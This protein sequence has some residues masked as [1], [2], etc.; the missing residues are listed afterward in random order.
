MISDKF[1]V[2]FALPFAMKRILEVKDTFRIENDVDYYYLLDAITTSKAYALKHNNRIDEEM[3]RKADTTAFMF[4]RQYLD[5]VR[6]Y[7]AELQAL[8]VKLL[9]ESSFTPTFE[10][11]YVHMEATPVER[12]IFEFVFFSI[13]SAGLKNM[14]SQLF[15]RY[16]GGDGVGTALNLCDVLGCSVDDV[17]AFY[18]S[19]SKWVKQKIVTTVGTPFDQVSVLSE[20]CCTALMGIPLSSKQYLSIESDTIRKFATKKKEEGNTA[21]ALLTCDDPDAEELPPVTPGAK[22]FLSSLT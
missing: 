14:A 20:G 22:I 10:R 9:A 19:N 8:R 4:Y 7:P 1:D 21:A 16:Y 15:M 17:L 2:E 13:C 5:E 3:L 18:S 6:S 12:D 11:F